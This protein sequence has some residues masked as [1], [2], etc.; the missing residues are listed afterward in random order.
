MNNEKEKVETIFPQE[1]KIDNISVSKGGM[2][3]REYAA[4]KLKVPD[5][6]TPWLDEMI[7]KSRRDDL[8]ARAMQAQIEFEGMEGC[9]S[10]LICG[11]GYYLSDTMLTASKG[12]K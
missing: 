6:G 7:E 10:K 5:S 1:E 2:T 9:D 3:L 8:A 11:M 12:E 4:I